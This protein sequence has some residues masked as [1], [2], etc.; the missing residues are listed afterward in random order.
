MHVYFVFTPCWDGCSMLQCVMGSTIHRTSQKWL[1]FTICLHSQGLRLYDPQHKCTHTAMK[2]GLHCLRGNHLSFGF[3]F[4]FELCDS[5]GLAYFP[6]S[7]P[8]EPHTQYT[9]LPSHIH[10]RHICLHVHMCCTQ[11]WQ[12]QNVSSRCVGENALARTSS[13]GVYVLSPLLC[14]SLSFPVPGPCRSQTVCS[15]NRLD[16]SLDS[17]AALVFNMLLH[18][19]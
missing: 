7:P 16:L 15:L 10:T 8:S 12:K 17:G 11:T 2:S 13:H 6:V 19:H 18:L 1:L 5:H 3:K 14:V 4:W 9:H